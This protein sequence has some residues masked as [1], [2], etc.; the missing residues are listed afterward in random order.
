MILNAYTDIV[1]SER[2]MLLF[3]LL[4]AMTI[5]GIYMF[6]KFAYLHS[7]GYP[8]FNHELRGSAFYEERMEVN[9]LLM[10]PPAVATFA[11]I[12]FA[13]LLRRR[14]KKIESPHKKETHIDE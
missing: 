14:V 7:L 4:F 11:S 1:I 13:S 12:V 9:I 6:L 2:W 10:L 5:S 3:S 8:V